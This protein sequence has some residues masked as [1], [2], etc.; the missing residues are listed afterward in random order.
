MKKQKAF[1]LIELLVIVSIMIIM[2]GVILTM[3]RG[4][5]DK[6]LMRASADK[7]SAT[8]REA[9]NGSLTGALINGERPCLFTANS[10][11]NGYGVIANTYDPTDPTGGCG[12]LDTNGDSTL[13]P[14]QPYGDG[15]TLQSGPNALTFSGSFAVITEGIGP[16][17]SSAKYVLQ[18]ASFEYTICVYR[19]GRVE[20][21][22]F[23][24]LAC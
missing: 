6:K 2:T 12:G 21:R 13:V 15:V 3:M 4:D 7:F 1:T 24:D 5:R 23:G 9:Q 11:P 20:S 18:N 14:T 22:G 16:S 17:D 8:I 10:D 19:S